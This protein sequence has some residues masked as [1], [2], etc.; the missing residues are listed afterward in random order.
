MFG[1]A[2]LRRSRQDQTGGYKYQLKNWCIGLWQ[3]VLYFIIILSYCSREYKF[4]T[5]SV[6]ELFRGWY[7]CCLK[8][9]ACCL[10]FFDCL[11]HAPGKLFGSIMGEKGGV[12]LFLFCVLL[13]EQWWMLPKRVLPPIPDPKPLLLASREPLL[14]IVRNLIIGYIYSRIMLK[15]AFDFVCAFK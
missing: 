15:S 13:K 10:Q 11:Q 3:S 12:I 8:N 9:G 6:F 1:D 2:G 7:V 14:F 4:V 5:I